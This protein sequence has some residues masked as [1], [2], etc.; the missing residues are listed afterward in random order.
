MWGLCLPPES[1]ENPLVIA[2]SIC[3]VLSPDLILASLASCYRY[4]HF[5]SSLLSHPTVTDP[6]F[7]PPGYFA[8]SNND[9][10]IQTPF[11][12]P[13]IPITWFNCLLA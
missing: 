7:V 13:V 2:A 12:R 1:E 5:T 9:P 10:H 4:T 6:L 3:V 8:Y 11:G